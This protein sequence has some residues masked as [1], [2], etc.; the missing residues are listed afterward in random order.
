MGTLDSSSYHNWR[1]EIPANYIVI[2]NVKNE[3]SCFIAGIKNVS[4][5]DLAKKGSTNFKEE[6]LPLINL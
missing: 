1:E 2:T 6:L 5:A 4:K 3:R